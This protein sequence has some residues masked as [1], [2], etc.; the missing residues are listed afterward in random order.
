MITVRP[1][2]Y[3]H[4]LA[5]WQALASALGLKKLSGPEEADAEFGGDGHLAL[6]GVEPGSARE[7]S[8]ELGFFTDRLTECESHLTAMG[9]EVETTHHIEGTGTTLSLVD[10]PV[11]IT[12]TQKM[13]R[14]SAGRLSM[15]PIFY[16]D[17]FAPLSNVFTALGLQL[18][19]ASNR[20]V[21]TDFAAFGGGLV[22]LHQPGGTSHRIEL[23]MEYH[24]QLEELAER[25]QQAG[26]AP[27]IVDEAY[28][29]TLR[30]PT[31]DGW[32]MSVNGVMEDM[33]GFHRF[34]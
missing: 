14:H 6:R 31:P 29:R 16:T 11:A 19:I 32:T 30:V 25:L 5:Q 24:E 21:W 12:I 17:D 26:F 34:N 10:S 8:V 1:I 15:C 3:T 28:N 9:Y 4:H 18:R 7:A 27:A 23:A 22:A 2:Y 20:G 33:Y 13:T